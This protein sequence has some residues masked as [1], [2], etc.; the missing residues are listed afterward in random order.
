L[1]QN[2]LSS[3]L[4]LKNVKIRTHKT[5]ILSV[6]LY[7]LRVFENRIL[8]IFGPKRDDVMGGWRKLHKK[9]LRDLYS[10]PG[11]IRTI[12]S[13]MMRWVGHAA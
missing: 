13:K 12:K 8:R 11:I 7:E 5:T 3:R 9:E 1:V 4:L 10:S 6:L 2:L